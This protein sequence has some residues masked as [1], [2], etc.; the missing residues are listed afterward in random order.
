MSPKLKP[1]LPI[2][3]ALFVAF[4]AALFTFQDYGMT[5][6]EY[7][8]Y[9]YGE[10]VGYAYSIP[11]HLSPD[12]DI[13]RAYGPSVG[14]HKVYG[15]IYLLITRIPVLALRNLTNLDIFS[16]WHLV[17]FSLFLV[18]VYYFYRLALRWLKPTAAFWASLLYLTQ[19]LLWGHGF[20]NPK[21]IPFVSIFTITLYYGFKWVDNF[22]PENIHPKNIDRVQI[23]LVVLLGILL[24]FATNLRVIAPYIA[25]L[26]F[27]Y[28]L[29][30]GKWRATL[31]FIPIGII[32]AVTLYITWPYLWDAP[33]QNFLGVLA[34]MSNNPTKLKVLFYGK[35]YRAYALPLRYLPVLLGITLTEPVWIVATLGLG[36]A[37]FKFWKKELEWQ[38]LGVTLIWFGLMAGYVLAVRPPMYDGFRHFLF[39]LP[40]I[41]ILT[42]FGIEQLLAWGKKE[43]LNTLVM[44][45]LLFYGV[46]GIISLHPYEYAYYNQ[47]VGGTSGA[48]GEF[49][50]DYW[51][52]CYKETVEELAEYVGNKETL[53][54]VYR[55]PQN[56]AFYAPANME[57]IDAIYLNPGDYLLLSARLDEV[58]M[59]ARKSG[60]IIEVGRNGATFCAIRE[61]KK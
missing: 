32:A 61:I 43:W 13:N 60:N 25:A 42:G 57:V 58:N 45:S 36:S 52:T 34:R 24:G 21:D 2:L 41:F 31:W 4:I 29:L 26:I 12:F 50:T 48:E 20:I 30:Q 18:G 28:A 55:E 1:H 56:A 11:A 33:I 53:L 23:R 38:S 54:Q 17:N 59:I 9:Q 39:I 6:D 22:T 5:W 44:V 16:L 40:P 15:P 14:D 8:Y 46:R 47:F 35:E 3:I 7:L 27:L 19:P 10:A 49:E 37:G 51:L